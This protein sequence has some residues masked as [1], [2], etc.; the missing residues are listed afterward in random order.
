MALNAP[1]IVAKFLKTAINNYVLF[2]LYIFAAAID[3]FGCFIFIAFDSLY[4]DS[5][6]SSFQSNLC[7]FVPLYLFQTKIFLRGY[8]TRSGHRSAHND[9]IRLNN[10]ETKVRQILANE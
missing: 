10:N 2:S 1:G 6:K 8:E 5:E 3:R 4:Y 7:D 9:K